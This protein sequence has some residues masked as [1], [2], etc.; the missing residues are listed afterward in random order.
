MLNPCY[1]KQCRHYFEEAFLILA[2]EMHRKCPI[3]KKTADVKSII[4]D[5]ILKHAMKCIMDEMEADL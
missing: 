2:V 4:N 1:L 5:K 3:C